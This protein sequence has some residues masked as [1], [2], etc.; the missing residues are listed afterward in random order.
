[1]MKFYLSTS[2]RSNSTNDGRVLIEKLRHLDIDGVELDYRIRSEMVPG[3]KK[4]LRK[5]NLGVSSIHNYFPVPEVFP[6]R[7][8]SGDFFNLAGLDPEERRKSIQWSTRTIKMAAEFGAG[9]VVLHCGKVSMNPRIEDLRH[10]FEQRTLENE[11]TRSFIDKKLT[12]YQSK[13]PPHLDALRFSLEKL[14]TAARK[15][16]VRLGLENRN[17]YHELPGMDDFEALFADFSGAPIGY[18]HDT[19]HEHVMTLLGFYPVGMPLR[20]FSDHLI[21]IH[22]HDAVGMHDHLPPGSGEFDFNQ[23]IINFE[24]QKVTGVFELNPEV[25]LEAAA[26]GIAWFGKGTGLRA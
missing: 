9:A 23:T 13:K 6:Q 19:G 18:W 2:I 8:G 7:Q 12:E 5:Y 10:A 16:G 17:H 25:S 14:V 4:A 21:G 20:K 3:I 1:M 26:N 22:I 24:K 11:A 15:H